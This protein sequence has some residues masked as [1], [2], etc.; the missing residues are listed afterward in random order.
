MVTQLILT[1]RGDAPINLH[2]AVPWGVLVSLKFEVNS[3]NLVVQ[4]P[5]NYEF[6]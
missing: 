5:W 1:T 3:Q 6:E 2:I 4:A